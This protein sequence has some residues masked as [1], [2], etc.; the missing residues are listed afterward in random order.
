MSP[1][2]C[3]TRGAALVLVL[4]GLLIVSPAATAIA[5][6]PDS[7]PLGSELRVDMRTKPPGRLTGVL[8]AADSNAMLLVPRGRP[9]I[10]VRYDEIASVAT[11]RGTQPRPGGAVRGA[12]QGFLVGAGIGVVATAI[13]L[14]F[15][16]NTSQEVFIPA[17]VVI[18]VY[19][20][21]LTVVTTLVGAAIGT[22]DVTRWERVW[23]R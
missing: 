22:S 19:S 6:R 9:P 15:D 1:D 20:L 12:K 23:P 17:S 5:Q 14:V 18:G 7:L 8:Q 16:L 10:L 21:G 2:H 11:A 3:A 4:T 13:A